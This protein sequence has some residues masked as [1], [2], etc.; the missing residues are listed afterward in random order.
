MKAAQ[1]YNNDPKIHVE[2]MASLGKN[3]AYQMMLLLD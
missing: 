3:S 2:S 1:C